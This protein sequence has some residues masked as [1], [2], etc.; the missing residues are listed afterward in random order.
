MTATC[1]REQPSAIFPNG[2]SCAVARGVAGIVL[3]TITRLALHSARVVAR[4]GWHQLGAAPARA[5]DF[6]VPALLS[7]SERQYLPSGSFSPNPALRVVLAAWVSGHTRAPLALRASP[8]LTGR[9][10][11]VWPLVSCCTACCTTNQFPSII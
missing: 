11:Y 1:T 6:L 10:K 8:T 7:A 4:L 5:L 9:V 2:D 3:G